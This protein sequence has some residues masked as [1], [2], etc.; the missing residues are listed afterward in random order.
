MGPN[1]INIGVYCRTH[2]KRAW[3]KRSQ[4]KKWARI[5]HRGESMSEY[6]CETLQMWHIGHTPKDVLAGLMTR[7]DLTLNREQ[8]MD[9]IAQL[10]QKIMD[11]ESELRTTLG[12][13]ETLIAASREAAETLD[14]SA[15]LLDRLAQENEWLRGRVEYLEDRVR[16]IAG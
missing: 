9:K 15:Q 1:G 5:R 13:L 2:G 7:E 11:L 6:W 3:D 16:D 8:R 4:A 10:N 14:K 12:N